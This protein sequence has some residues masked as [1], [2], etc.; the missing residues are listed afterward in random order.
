MN[1]LD[2]LA[3]KYNTDKNSKVHD[4]TSI[5]NEYFENVRGD[6]RNILEIGVL[7]GSSL[8]MWENYFENANIYGID[9]NID[10]KKYEGDRRIVLIG[11][12]DDE[13]FIQRE[14]KN[15]N[16]LF[17]LIIDDG[18]HVSDHQIKSFYLLFENLR[19]RS[20]YI[21][22]DVCCSYWL[23]S[24]YGATPQ[25]DGGLKKPGTCIEHFKDKVDD[26]NF[27]GAKGDVYD[28]KREH[29]LTLKSELTFFEKNVRSITFY[30]SLI[31]IQKI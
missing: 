2:E 28:R 21:I 23:G 8:K 9:K 14:I 29:M 22:E 16:L 13:Q 27:F 6:Y 5:Y 26:I 20:Y 30:N 7:N 24:V 31:V 10:C 3:I 11:E 15:K 1:H 19:S 12:Q 18:S 4:F 17:D 25:N